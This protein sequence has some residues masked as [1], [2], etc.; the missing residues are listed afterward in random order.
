MI[1]VIL[2]VLAILYIFCKISNSARPK[3]LF[4]WTALVEG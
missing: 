1:F 3:Y 2:S 4:A